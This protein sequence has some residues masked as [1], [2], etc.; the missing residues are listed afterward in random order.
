MRILNDKHIFLLSIVLS[1][2]WLEATPKE[3]KLMSGERLIGEVLPS[4]SDETLVLR[5]KLLGELKLSRDLVSSIQSLPESKPVAELAAKKPAAVA[6]PAP[7]PTPAPAVE[8]KPAPKIAA[9]KASQVAS[10]EPKPKAKSNR[11]LKP[12][13]A[14]YNFKTPPSWSGNLRLGMNL[15]SGTREWSESYARGQ[16][17]IQEKGS[18]NLYRLAGSYSYRKNTRTNGTTYVSSDKFDINGL[19]RRS[20]SKGWFA[21]NA[22]GYRVDN[23]K[24]ID[25]EFKNSLGL[26]YKFKVFKDKIELNLGGGFGLEEFKAINSSDI[27]NGTNYIGNT[28]QEFVWKLPMKTTLSQKFNYFMN[29]EDSELYN[30]LFSISLRTRLTDVFG[31]ELSYRQDL[32]SQVGGTKKD[33]KQW[34]SAFVVYF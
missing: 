11:L 29:M 25:H 28:F 24:G 27:R 30:F 34:R 12:I 20:F 8:V 6:K 3:V 18:P 22:L 15:T 23:V 26:G 4:S 2:A 1:C 14:I 21:Q 19:Y 16:L 13:L 7:T 17:S 9:A 10:K 5:S 31:L 32:D 33:D